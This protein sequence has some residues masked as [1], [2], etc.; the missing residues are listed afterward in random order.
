MEPREPTLSDL[1]LAE[2]LSHRT[3][4][5]RE[6]ALWLGADNGII[7]QFSLPFLSHSVGELAAL[8]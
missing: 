7:N 1:T 2:I 6:D 8:A 5:A 4:L 3:C